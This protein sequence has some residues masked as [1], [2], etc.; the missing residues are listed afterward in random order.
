MKKVKVLYFIDRM[1]RGGIQTFVIENINHMDRNEIQIDFLL[2]DDGRKYDD[3][4]KIL[5]DMG[6]NIYKL[7]GIWIRKPTDFIKYNK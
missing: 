3:E 2:L 7:N 1:L 6:C 5:K 4:E